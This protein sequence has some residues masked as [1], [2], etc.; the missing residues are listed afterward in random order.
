M[1]REEAKKVLERLEDEWIY[2]RTSRVV[3]DAIRLA[4]TALERCEEM[5]AISSQESL[6]CLCGGHMVKDKKCVLRVHP[7]MYRY[8]C[9]D[10]GKWEIK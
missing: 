6:V 8:V 1:N 9:A 3:P 10:C 4:I 2:G 5:D 7:P